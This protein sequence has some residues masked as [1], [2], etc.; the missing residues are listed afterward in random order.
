MTRKLRMGMVGGGKD[1]FIGAVHRFAANLDGRIELVAG[2][3][4][5]N[6]KKSHESGALFLLSPDRVYDSYE[7][8]AKQEAALPADQRIDFVSIVTPNFAHYPAA[9]T[10]LEAGFN[11]ICDK[12]M[13]LNLEEALKLREVVRKSG[14]VF[15]LTHNYTG[16][17]MVKEARA[18]VRGGELGKIL[19]IV[20]EYPQGGCSIRSIRKDKSRPRG[21]PIRSGPAPVAASATSA[22][23]A[24]IW[25]ATLAA[26][27]SKNCALTLPRLS[28]AGGLKTMV[29]CSCATRMARAVCSMPRRSPLARRTI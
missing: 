28:K 20:T 21:A 4:S 6:P 7:A 14:K 19:K 27:K 8:M 3:F 5:S 12:P 22:P 16:Y 17:P 11:V 13:T 29:T 26:W 15:A 24:K 25:L 18:M 2:A 10:F 1:A 9:K 23:T